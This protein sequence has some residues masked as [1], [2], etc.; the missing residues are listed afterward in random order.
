V[1]KERGELKEGWGEANTEMT[2]RTITLILR[3]CVLLGSL[4]KNPWARSPGPV[5]AQYPMISFIE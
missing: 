3:G 2:E 5:T 4:S 1:K